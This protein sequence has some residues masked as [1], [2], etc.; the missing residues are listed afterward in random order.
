MQTPQQSRRAFLQRVTIA[1]VPTALSLSSGRAFGCIQLTCTGGEASL[2]NTA[3]HVAS[4]AA[5]QQNYIIPV[6]TSTS[7]ILRIVQV[8]FDNYLQTT[9]KTPLY[10]KVNRKGVKV[11]CSRSDV[12]AWQNIVFNKTV[13]TSES[14]TQ[15]YTSAKRLPVNYDKKLVDSN[16]L[17]DSFFPEMGAVTV[18][19]ALR[20]SDPFTKYVTAAFVGALW[21]AHPEYTLRFGTKCYPKIEEIMHAYNTVRNRRDEQG[22]LVG[23]ADMGRLFKLYTKSA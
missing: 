8:D 4:V 23:L 14:C 5:E 20:S 1:A 16:T 17:M 18:A 12:P 6:W 2:S 15:K 11:S 22:R 10:R 7:E 19:K 9:F 13:Y 21:E 3:S